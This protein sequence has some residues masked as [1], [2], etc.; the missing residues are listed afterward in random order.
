MLGSAADAEDAVQDTL[1]RAYERRS[2][3]DPERGALSSWLHRI[4]TRICLDRLRSAE[5]R[6]LFAGPER[7]GGAELGA[8]LPAHRWVEPISGGRLFAA[9]DPA[10]TAVERESVRLAFVALV[11]HLPPRQRAVLLLRD[12]LA[13][14]AAEC[15]EVLDTTVASVTSALQRARSSLAAAREGETQTELTAPEIELLERYIRAFE[16]HDVRGLTALLSDDA[17]TGMP[18]FEWWVAGGGRIAAL[19]GASDACAE[20]R[21]TIADVNGAPGIAQYRP[22]ADGVLRPFSLVAI[23]AR[24]GRIARITTFLGAGDRFS[25]FGLPPV[26]SGTSARDR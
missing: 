26:F 12:V 5:R 6:L 19:M 25:E 2:Q 15:A 1:I 24:D 16:S 9:D 13:Y 18:P 22:D 7:T 20:D 11:Q 4:A 21:L 14:S 17:I 3:Y 10:D 8:P 23:E